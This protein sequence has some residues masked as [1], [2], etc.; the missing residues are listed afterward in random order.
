[1]KGLSA[2]ACVCFVGALVMGSVAAINADNAAYW[3]NEHTKLR[4]EAI[5]HGCAEWRVD[6]KTGATEF[7]WLKAER[8]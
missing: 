2:F 4:Q 3:R 8:E 1:M 6:P 7:V 5:D